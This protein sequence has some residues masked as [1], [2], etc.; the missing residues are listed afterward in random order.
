VGE[1]VEQAKGPKPVLSDGLGDQRQFAPG[2]NALAIEVEDV[3][4]LILDALT[5]KRFATY[6]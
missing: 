4:K 2:Q 5:N 6:R 3:S 1:V